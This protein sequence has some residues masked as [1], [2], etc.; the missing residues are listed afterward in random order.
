MKIK[1]YTFALSIGLWMTSFAEPELPTV[2]LNK[3][4]SVSPS[5]GVGAIVGNTI[6]I[7]ITNS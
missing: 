6:Y 2:S 4:T 5:G 3:L 7:N 1:F